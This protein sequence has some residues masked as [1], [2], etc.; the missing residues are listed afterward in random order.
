MAEVTSTTTKKGIIPEIQVNGTLVDSKH[1]ARTGETLTPPGDE[2]RYKNLE[3]DLN[4]ESTPFSNDESLDDDSDTSL[5]ITSAQREGAINIS[6]EIGDS[7]EF[8]QDIDPP[9]TSM[10]VPLANTA[11]TTGVAQSEAARCDGRLVVGL[12]PDN[13]QL[14]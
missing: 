4:G 6:P 2:K 5:D 1:R 11:K 13:D 12:V 10:Q 14:R 9:L 8:S 3:S 7:L